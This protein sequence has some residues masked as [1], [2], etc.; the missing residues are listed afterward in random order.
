MI[1]SV[2]GHFRVGNERDVLKRFQSRSPYIR[3]LVDEVFDPPEP[4]IIML[5]HLDDHLL[6]ASIKQKLNR[7]EVKYVSKRILEAL[8]VLHED[9]FVHAGMHLLGNE[10]HTTN[11][12]WQMLS[13]TTCSLAMHLM[14]P[15]IGSQMFSLPTL[16]APTT[17]IQS[18]PR[19][20]HLLESQSGEAQNLCLSS[21][22][23]PRLMSGHLEP[24]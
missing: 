9:G 19:K 16:A 13:R 2:Q 24:W 12:V 18:M 20:A 7:T 1:K 17:L 14:G 15:A 22:G 4:P 3:P 11:L 23:I 21:H 6:K 5:R 10:V 8:N